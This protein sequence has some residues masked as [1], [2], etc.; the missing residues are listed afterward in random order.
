MRSTAWV[1]GTFPTM[2]GTTTRTSAAPLLR[3]VTL[4]VSSCADVSEV[5]RER[6]N[7]TGDAPLA[8]SH[9]T[10]LFPGGR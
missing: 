5:G 6:Q 1:G 9:K 2:R 3:E 7:L 10:L 8:G 4:R